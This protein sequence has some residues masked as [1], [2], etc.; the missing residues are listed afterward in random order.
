MV[1]EL[2]KNSRHLED[3]LG[4]VDLGFIVCIPQA[5]LAFRKTAIN[6]SSNSVQLTEP[7]R[8]FYSFFPHLSTVQHPCGGP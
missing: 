4:R 7:L 5:I 8:R 1:P 6:N 3:F 2:K